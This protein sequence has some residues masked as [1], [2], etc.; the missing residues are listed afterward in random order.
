MKQGP[1]HRPPYARQ[2]P[3]VLGAWAVRAAKG[4]DVVATGKVAEVAH[5]EAGATGAREVEAMVVVV[6]AAEGSA[7]EVTVEGGMVEVAK[8]AEAAMGGVA[9]VELADG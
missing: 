7:A 9:E 1:D 3:G 4:K 6:T 2:L 8:V 5:A